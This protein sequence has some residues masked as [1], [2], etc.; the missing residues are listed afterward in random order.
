VIE[1]GASWIGRVLLP[2]LLL[3]D[4]AALSRLPLGEPPEH[5]VLRLSW[6][7][8]GA[9]VRICRPYT[10]EERRTIP[11]HM[12]RQGEVC[13]Q[14][15][16]P[17]RLRLWVD[18]QVRLDAVVRPGGLREDRP[19]FVL[20]DLALP[21]GPRALRVE[22]APTEAVPEAGAGHDDPRALARQAAVRA[23]ARYELEASVQMR[24]G[25]ILLL[26]LDERERRFRVVEG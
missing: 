15:V 18:G 24:S 16:L 5:G 7:M 23:A 26:D 17:Y 12:Q 19:L 14:T 8:V 2:A 20:E 3:L 10:E 6:R 11:Q 4:I 22:F 1:R 9:A 21:P 25:R 13:D